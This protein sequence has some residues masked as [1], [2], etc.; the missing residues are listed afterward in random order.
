M[1]YFFFA[2]MEK[3]LFRQKNQ[4]IGSLL[5]QLRNEK[6]I[7]QIDLQNEGFINQSR[8]SKIENGE[9]IISAVQ[10][11]EFAERYGVSITYF[12]E[13]LNDN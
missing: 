7:K 4:I 3:K 12:Y 9:V 10:L 6:G 13:K 2:V 11:M 8:L 1:K 5:Y